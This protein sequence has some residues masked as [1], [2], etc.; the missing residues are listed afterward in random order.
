MSLTTSPLEMTAAPP[1]ITPTGGAPASRSRKALASISAGWRNPLLRNGYLLT[2]SS[3]VS[4]AIGFGYWAVA[5]WGYDAANVGSNSAAISMMVLVA[6]IAQLN[7]SSAMVRF[8]PTAGQHTGRLVASSFAVSSGLA[9]VISTVAVIAVRVVSPGTTFLSGI[10]PMAMFVIGTVVYSLFVIQNGVLVGLYRAGLV[11]LVNIVFAVAKLALVVALAA[12]MPFH[13]IFASWVAALCVVV[14]SVGVFLFGWAIPRHQRVNQTHDL[15]PVR[16]IGRFVAFDYAGSILSIGSIDLMPI[17]VIAVLGAAPNAY[18]AIA[19]VIAYTLHLVNTNMGT[20]LVAETASN[21]DRLAHGV[22]HVLSHSAKLLVPVVAVTIVAAP[23]LLGIFGSDYRAAT[24]TLRLL[25]LAAIPNIVVSTAISSA[26]AQRRLGLLLA[27]QLTQCVVVLSLTW[28]LLHAAG[29]A[30]AGL[31]WLIAQTLMAGGL[32]VYRHQWMNSSAP[33]HDGAYARRLRPVLPITVVVQL[34]QLLTKLRLRGVVDRWVARVRGLRSRRPAPVQA[35]AS[36][37]VADC[38]ETTACTMAQQVHTVSDVDVAILR[39]AKEDPRAVVKLARGPMGAYE[40]RTQRLVLDQFASD[41]RL[42]DLQPLLPRVLAFR[43]AAEGAMSV[44]TFRP[45]VNLADLLE[46]LPD[47]AE[48]LTTEALAS[49]AL[50]HRRT[51]MSTIVDD[52]H[53]QS[54]VG[55]PL[56]TLTEICQRMEPRLSPA[57]DHVGQ[58]LCSALAH[59][60]VLVSWTHGD[61]TPNNIQLHGT[62]GPVTG[63]VDWGGARPGQLSLLDGYLLSLSVS[64]IVEARELGAIVRRRLRA[65]G[66][67]LRERRPLRTVYHAAGAVTSACDQ[68]DERAAILLTWLHHAADMWRKCSAYRE[69]RIWWAAN[70]AP[71][72]RVVITSALLNPVLPSIRRRMLPQST[73]VTQPADIV[74]AGPTVAV[75]ICAYTEDRWDDLIAAVASV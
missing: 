38:P 21:P 18:F 33:N 68:L 1:V 25:A 30:G 7:L 6:A 19:W 24:D 69:H 39:S 12:V 67:L 65:G 42:D 31:A 53:L 58:V 63:I 50:L 74:V 36:S 40:L 3:G 51:G 26:R 41:P 15:P 44:E 64:R 62:D 16:Q 8:V 70:I 47:Q 59:R 73:V 23:L 34:L 27:I 14:F 2:I 55:E 11:P 13:G 35:L 72:L 54:W 37:V 29:L 49:I 43:D 32:L 56:A 60:K 75:V 22:R 66:L 4:A 71:V 57:V 10:L 9:V 20:S 48:E 61:F 45:G 5:A 52:A 17:M 28:V 46:R